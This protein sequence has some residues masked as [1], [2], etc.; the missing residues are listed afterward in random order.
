MNLCIHCKWYSPLG[1]KNPICMHESSTIVS[2]VDG[3]ETFITCET[4]RSSFSK[5]RCGP[6]GKFWQVKK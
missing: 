2:P 1:G 3:H 6:D 5:E 4:Q